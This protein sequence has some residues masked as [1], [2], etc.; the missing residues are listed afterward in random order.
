M[1]TQQKS[2]MAADRDTVLAR[3]MIGP[4]TPNELRQMGVSH[5][6]GRISELRHDL[7][8]PI[9]TIFFEGVRAYALLRN[10]DAFKGGTKTRP[11]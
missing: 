6:E 4:V 10:S 7:G 3:L 8:K 2:R 9:G 11:L 5:P 1:T